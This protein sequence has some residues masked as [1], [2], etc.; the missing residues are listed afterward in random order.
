MIFCLICFLF[1]LLFTLG[2][3][4]QITGFDWCTKCKRGWYQTQRGQKT[5]KECPKGYYCPVSNQDHFSMCL[6]VVGKGC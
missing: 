2:F 4:K 1:H 3:V 6:L 5:C